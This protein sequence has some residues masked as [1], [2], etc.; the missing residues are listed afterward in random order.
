MIDLS[1]MAQGSIPPASTKYPKPNRKRL[2]FF[3]CKRAWKFAGF[4]IKERQSL[5][6]ATYYLIVFNVYAVFLDW[7]N[8]AK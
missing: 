6:I 1:G 5:P 3:M 7:E 4:T 8:S 2:G